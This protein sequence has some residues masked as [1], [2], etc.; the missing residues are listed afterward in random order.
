[1][2]GLSD[3]TVA[4]IRRESRL[5]EAG[6][7]AGGDVRRIGSDGRSRPVD[8]ASRRA[9][10]T[11]LLVANPSSSL[12]HIAGLA[13]VS[14][15]TVRTIRSSLGNRDVPVASA[16]TDARGSGTD[17]KRCLRILAADPAL[18]STDAGRL[19][20]RLLS[21]LAVI[22]QDRTGLLEAV[23]EHDLPVFERLATAHAEAWRA[24][25]HL[26]A[27]RGDRAEI[28]I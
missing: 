8:A 17:P 5:A 15:E 1:V 10:V 4:V 24:L 9:T 2:A 18:R 12:R 16:D 20:L 14:P 7:E 21:T 28:L 23:P 25:A 27:T 19:L 11:Q 26:A 13:G 22:D 3:K 6:G